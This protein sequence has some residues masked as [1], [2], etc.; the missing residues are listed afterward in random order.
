MPNVRG[1]QNSSPAALVD[2]NSDNE[3]LDPF[4]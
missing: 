2:P 4:E 3:G 1:E